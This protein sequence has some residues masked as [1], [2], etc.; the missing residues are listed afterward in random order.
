[1]EEV[2]AVCMV[3]VGECLMAEVVAVCKVTMG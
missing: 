2:V 3:M 1:M